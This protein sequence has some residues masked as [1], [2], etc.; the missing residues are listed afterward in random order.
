MLRH[1]NPG[2]PALMGLHADSSV[3]SDPLDGLCATFNIANETVS[4]YHLFS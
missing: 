3:Y 1:R 2:L 4:E